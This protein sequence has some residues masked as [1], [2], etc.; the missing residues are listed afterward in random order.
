VNAEST[1]AQSKHG[2][3]SGG[4]ALSKAEMEGFCQLWVLNKVPLEALRDKSEESRYAG[5]VDLHGSTDRLHSPDVELTVR[6]G[7]GQI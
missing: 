5:Q 7:M 6:R 1:Q 2:R 3:F 4:L